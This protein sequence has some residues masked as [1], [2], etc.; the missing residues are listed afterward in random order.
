MICI[1][2]DSDEDES[3]R[4]KSARKREREDLD[5]PNLSPAPSEHRRW[6]RYLVDC[7]GDAGGFDAMLVLMRNP[8]VVSLRLL[9]VA[10]RPV[11][12]CAGCLEETF[13]G[14]LEE[15]AGT[16]LAYLEAL[17][18]D[19]GDRL[20][21]GGGDARDRNYAHVCGALRGARELLVAC[22]GAG[23]AERRVSD[24]HRAVVKG[25]LGVSTFNSQLAA[26]REINAMLD[27]TRGETSGLDAADAAAAVRVAVEW[28]ESERV[29]PHVL[30][31]VY[32]HHKQ[33]VDQ[34]SAI[35]RRLLQEGAARA[36]YLDILW[37]VTRKPDT[38]EE[39]KHNVY[40]LLA[41]LAWHFSEE[42]LDDLFRRVGAAGKIA[43]S[44]DA[45]K[46]LEMVQKLARSDARGI[47]A[48]RLL[49]L[50]WRMTH[51][52][53]EGRRATRR[54]SPP[55][56]TSSGTTNE[57]ERRARLAANG[58]AAPSPA[59][60]RRRRRKPR[61][62]TSP[63]PIHRLLD[64]GACVADFDGEGE[65]AERGRVVRKK[66][67]GD[68][69]AVEA[70]GSA[71]RRREWIPPTRPRRQPPR[72]SPRRPGAV[73]DR[74]VGTWRR[75]DVRA[76]V[77][78]DTRR[79]WT[80]SWTRRSS[81]VTRGELAPTPESCRRL[82]RAFVERPPRDSGH[83]GGGMHPSGETYRDRGLM[84]MTKLL[85]TPPCVLS[86]A[87]VADLLES[88]LVEEPADA[89]TARGW[90]LF[91][92]FFLQ[93][94]LDAGRLVPREE[95]R[96]LAAED[97]EVEII[98]PPSTDGRRSTTPTRFPS[99]SR[100]PVPRDPL[101]DSRRT[102]ARAVIDLDCVRAGANPSPARN[103]CGES[104]STRRRR[105]TPR[106]ASPSPST[107]SGF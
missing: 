93:A 44:E 88:R 16:T 61:R 38:F 55:S 6:L 74:G 89:V 3:A 11:A 20:V 27:G 31:P 39:V 9:E 56:P 85:T 10:I 81:A 100:I 105:R 28:L 79:R 104:R 58:P 4:G 82:W 70:A 13:L 48:E 23:E 92:S 7:F 22:V 86:E 62:V 15:A 49:E 57:R 102:R 14:S 101:D 43:L 73:P 17:A 91:E 98:S 95:A 40:D 59:S 96:H 107:P 34:V 106:R 18:E 99:R 53:E 19:G 41:A 12:R 33:Y 21:G 50:L 94:G 84:W 45:G 8:G 24:A 32:L 29:L 52:G 78:G 51:S 37:D 97:D 66:R 67:K 69:I 77:G 87:C 47:M 35:L 54:R 1:E 80:R 42:Q 71:A 46:I 76:R 60:R 72:P 68:A 5:F 65:R 30:R 2:A 83:S 75:G 25:M 90:C 103:S 26:L 36:E 63:V 64:P